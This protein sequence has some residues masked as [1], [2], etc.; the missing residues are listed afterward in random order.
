MDI[1]CFASNPPK[2]YLAEDKRLTTK[3]SE[4]NRA[5]EDFYGIKLTT[6]PVK[7]FFIRDQPSSV[8]EIGAIPKQVAIMIA[9]SYFYGIYVIQPDS[10]EENARIIV[11]EFGCL[12]FWP[13]IYH[14]LQ[15]CFFMEI[16]R[17]CAPYWLNEGLSEM[18]SRGLPEVCS[19]EKVR[20][21]LDCFEKIDLSQ[22]DAAHLV[23]SRLVEI[24]G[25][26]KIVELLLSMKSFVRSEKLT[27][28]QPAHFGQCFAKV[29]GMDFDPEKIT[30]LVCR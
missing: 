11:P 7:V 8:Q 16:A 18:H 27:I 29:Y 10:L 24:F 3:L 12:P 13:V 19:R 26:G 21:V 25:P 6:R 30:E 28:F 5:L 20:S 17:C 22:Y 2:V 1:P 14:E 4:Y 23:V 9:N 15:H